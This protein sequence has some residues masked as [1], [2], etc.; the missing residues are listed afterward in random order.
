MSGAVIVLLAF[1]G[2]VLVLGLALI[3]RAR[4]EDMPTLA[5]ALGHWL[6]WWSPFQ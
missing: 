4:P 6:C 3:F 2:V 5:R 1:L